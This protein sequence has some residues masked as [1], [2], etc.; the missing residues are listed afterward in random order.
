MTVP[1]WESKSL[2][3]MNSEEWE[4]LCDGCALCCLQK[5]EDEDTE[6]IYFTDVACRLLDTE[7]CRCTDYNNR[8][9]RVSACLVLGPDTPEVFHWLPASCAYRRLA[10][11]RSLPSWHPLLTGDTESVHRAGISLRGQMVSETEASDWTVLR[12]L[13]D[14]SVAG[15]DGS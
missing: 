5:L 10:E 4:S 7:R 6:E 1:F 2:A 8:A 11:G 13:T 9:D 15:G 3:E 12:S 14:D